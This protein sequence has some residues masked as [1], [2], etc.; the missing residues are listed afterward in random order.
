MW[1]SRTLR[2]LRVAFS[3]DSMTWSPAQEISSPDILHCYKE[4]PFTLRWGVGGIS[5]SSD[6]GFF[7][8]WTDPDYLPID[9]LS[10][11]TEYEKGFW[12]ISRAAGMCRLKMTK[13]K[14][15]FYALNFH[16]AHLQL[17]TQ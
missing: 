13:H 14:M 7:F 1:L 6:G 5:L 9:F 11:G 3:G 2:Y 15:I 12:Y 16:L 8:S 17:G 10:F 4:T